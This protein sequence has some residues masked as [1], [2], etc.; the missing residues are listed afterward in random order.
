MED[1]EF[2]L[3]KV[4]DNLFEKYEGYFIRGE[5]EFYQNVFYISTGVELAS[6]NEQYVFTQV[7]ADNLNDITDEQ[8]E[9]LLT[10]RLIASFKKYSP[11]S[12]YDPNTAQ[13]Y[14]SVAEYVADLNEAKQNFDEL[15]EMIKAD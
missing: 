5:I 1:L 10:S 13:N 14:N 9:K 6:G 12:A 8:I 11:N 7:R 2:R 15:A 3:N 4:Y